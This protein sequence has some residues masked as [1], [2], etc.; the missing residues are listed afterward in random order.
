[1]YK[2]HL[3]SGL[4]SLPAEAA[5]VDWAAVNNAPTAQQIQVTVYQ[6]PAGGAKTII[7]PGVL[8]LMVDP[9]SVVHNANPVGFGQPF[10]PGMYYE[11]AIDTNDRRVL[12][13]VSMWS[14]HGGTM[15]PGTLISS[16]D[17]LHLVDP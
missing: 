7:T 1:M 15:I 6:G 14:D 17:F 16:R 3:S 10:V 9:G 2:Y 11:V 4:F 5:S 12:P 8:T 13:M